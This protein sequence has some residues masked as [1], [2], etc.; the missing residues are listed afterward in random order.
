MFHAYLDESGTV[1]PFQQDDRFLVIAVLTGQHHTI[2]AIE[3]HVKKVKKKAGKNAGSE[4]KAWD[5]TSQQMIE[6]LEGLAVTDISIIAVVIDKSKVYKPPKDTEDWYRNAVSEA[7][8]YCTKRHPQLDLTVDKRY[9][10]K[11]LRDKLDEVIRARI[12]DVSKSYV[13]IKHLESHS[14]LPLQA[15]DYIALAVRRKYQ[16]GEDQ[17]YNIIKDRIV[18]EVVIKEK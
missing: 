5:A 11:A 3:R 12:S 13:D 14:N 8:L 1:T 9:T 7:L 4:I 15:T 6:M 2:R 17:Y 10:K 16:D 18:M